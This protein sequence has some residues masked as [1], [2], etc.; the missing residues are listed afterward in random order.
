MSRSLLLL[1]CLLLF[2]ASP[3]GAEPVFRWEPVQP[4]PVQVSNP[5]VATWDGRIYV[6]GG[7]AAEGCTARCLVLDPA[8]GWSTLADLPLPRSGHGAAVAGGRIYVVGGRDDQGRLLDRVDILDPR[9][10]RWEQGP[11]LSAP[12]A[13]LAVASL[14][15]RVLAVGGSEAGREATRRVEVLEPGAEAWKAAHFLPTPLS[16][17]AAAGL[18]N[19][20]VVAGGARRSGRSVRRT[21]RY[22]MGAWE[23]GLPLPQERSGGSLALLG[24]RLVVAGGT[25]GPGQRALDKVLVG[26]P[27]TAWEELPPILA[28]PGVRAIG[29]QGRIYLLGGA[30]PEVLCGAWRSDLHGWVPERDLGFHLAEFGEP[31]RPGSP[32]DPILSPA[33]KADITNIAL[34]GLQGLGFPIR[35]PQPEGKTFYLKYFAYPAGLDAAASARRALLPLAALQTGGAHDLASLI[36]SPRGVILKKGV[37]APT[38]D[39]FTPANPYPQFRPPTG[40]GAQ[41][42]LDRSIPFATVYVHPPVGAAP[43]TLAGTPA[44][45]SADGVVAFHRELLELL[46]RSFREIEGPDPM[47]F[48]AFRDDSEPGRTAI[49]RIPR[50]PLVFDNW[51]TLPMPQDPERI[52]LTGLL[53]VYRDVYEGE[54]FRFAPLDSRLLEVGSVVRLP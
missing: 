37:I 44:A 11:R 3:A 40:A 26:R 51:R 31:E 5:A 32:T 2:L 6:L 7:Q 36:T 52:F 8:S 15:G 17:A 35:D 47:K 18:E 13:D 54:P 46:P 39:P 49:L 19:T 12:R 28:R 42:A 4:L 50:E 30:H 20:V 53:L 24:D 23:E 33:W 9:T 25:A 14:E 48:R 27:S 21:F 1:L 22:R 16:H 29:L 38:G 41:E 43:R 34:T 10:G 45:G